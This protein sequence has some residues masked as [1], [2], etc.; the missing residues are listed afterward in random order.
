MYTAL[1]CILTFLE[2]LILGKNNTIKLNEIFANGSLSDLIKSL[3]STIYTIKI[4]P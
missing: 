4:Y 2:Q 1:R 3:L